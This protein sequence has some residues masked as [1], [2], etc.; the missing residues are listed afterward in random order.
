M[1][2]CA[3]AYPS[4]TT[5]PPPPTIPIPTTHSLPPSSSHHHSSPS[6][7]T[8]NH[9]HSDHSHTHEHG[10][11]HSHSHEAGNHGHTHEIWPSPGSYINREQPIDT[12]RSWA[13]RAFTVGI[14]GYSI[15]IP[16]PSLAFSLAMPCLYQS[17]MH[18]LALHF[19]VSS[20]SVLTFANLD[21]WDLVSIY[22]VVQ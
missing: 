22:L 6:L 15:Y 8:M 3:S 17:A 19:L 13:E 9:D 1:G 20:A 2:D 7:S 12:G 10:G 5:T 16:Y 18:C 14:G 21:P 4:G 11:S